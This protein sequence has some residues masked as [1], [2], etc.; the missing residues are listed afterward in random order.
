MGLLLARRERGVFTEAPVR[1]ALYSVEL[2]MS[3]QVTS[4]TVV[5]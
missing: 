1:K 3:G 4:S 2:L 5:Q